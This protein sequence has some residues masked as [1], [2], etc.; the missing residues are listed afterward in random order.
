MTLHSGDTVSVSRA[1]GCRV[2]TVRSVRT[3]YVTVAFDRDHMETFDTSRRKI[4]RV[5][6]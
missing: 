5:T 1:H 2:G 3:G 6:G 4:E